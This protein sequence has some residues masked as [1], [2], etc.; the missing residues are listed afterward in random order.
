MDNINKKSLLSYPVYIKDVFSIISFEKEFNIVGS[1]S[2]RGL[3]YGSD[4]DLNM[5]IADISKIDQ[6]FKHLFKVLK[7]SKQ[8]YF[9][10]FKAGGY[11]WTIDEVLQ[12][13][14]HISANRIKTFKE[15]LHD[16]D[17]IKL[18]IIDR[19]NYGDFTEMSMIYRIDQES[20]TLKKHKSTSVEKVTTNF[21]DDIK[22]FIDEKNYF[23]ALKRLF[24]V[25]IIK[26]KDS[27][28]AKLLFDF[29][30]SS[31]GII[32]KVKSNFDIFL[33]LLSMYKMDLNELKFSM[34]TQKDYLNQIVDDIFLK[35]VFEKI[36]EICKAKNKIIF[37]SKLKKLYDELDSIL[38]RETMDWINKHSAIKK[39]LSL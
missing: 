25:Y 28:K 20:K 31:L 22:E 15:S 30:N 8:L 5:H 14:K 10:D 23:K 19:I 13:I 4:Y 9:L 24:S 1:N 26:K 33:K 27:D 36:D 3:L 21:I 12:G 2:I 7:D 18:D 39:E 16:P 6:M 11:H 29:F 37:Q 32:S 34:Q 35:H 17:V 38:Q